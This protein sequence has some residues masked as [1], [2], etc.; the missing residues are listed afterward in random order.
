MNE[1]KSVMDSSSKLE[2]TLN[3]KHNSIAYHLV[4]WNVAAGVVRIGWIEGILNIAYALTKILAAARR[5]KLFGYWTYLN[6]ITSREDQ[7]NMVM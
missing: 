2:S 7:V 3:K 6:R 4:R 5:S 1:N